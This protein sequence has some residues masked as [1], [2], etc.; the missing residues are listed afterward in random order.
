MSIHGLQY[1]LEDMKPKPHHILLS[2]IIL[3][4]ALRLYHLDYQPLWLDENHTLLWLSEN[5]VFTWRTQDVHPP[6]YFA[7]L[8]LIS[9]VALL[10]PFLIRLPSVIFGVAAIPLIYLLGTRLFSQ[11]EGLLAAFLLAI[12]VHHIHYS[13][14]ARMYSMVLL[15]VLLTIYFLYNENPF[16]I[17]IFVLA[18]Y[19]HYFVLILSPII[20]IYS[21]NVIRKNRMV[22]TF[23]TYL[24]LFFLL[25]LY[26]R[27][28]IQ[29]SN[30]LGADA[31]WA[32]QPSWGFF[33]YVFGQFTSFISELEIISYILLFL[34][35]GL[36]AIGLFSK[37]KKDERCFL[38]SWLFVPVA[39]SFALAF[40]MP[41]HPRY[42]IYCMPAFLLLVARGIGIITDVKHSGAGIRLV[43]IL[44][45]ISVLTA[46]PLLVSY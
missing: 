36:F 31:S 30:K 8:W 24:S 7:V 26:S 10:T 17:P 19:T 41:V 28:I 1:S 23:P 14:E 33:V 9:R 25:P 38:S 6:L 42:I 12:S 34:F 45:T 16:A 2:I 35:C 4:A 37:D 27:L 22:L 5:A 29:S 43:Q 18:A 39:A 46:L 44:T 32:L 11:K 15:L 20:L 13:Q 21:F 40:V 3:A